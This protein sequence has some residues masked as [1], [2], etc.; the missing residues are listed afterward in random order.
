[1]GSSLAPGGLLVVRE[2]VR[3]MSEE[4]ALFAVNMLVLTPR[5]STYTAGEYETWLR[6]AGLI[7]FE[8]V[9]IPG[10]EAHLILARNS[11]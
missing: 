1:M 10:A 11:R 4:A 5:A 3:G 8:A 9:P 6:E 7:G 2:F